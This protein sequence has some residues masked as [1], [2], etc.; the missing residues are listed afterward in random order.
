MINDLQIF[1]NEQFGE[2]KVIKRENGE[3]LFELYSV[4]FALGY[5]RKVNSKGKDYIQVRKDRVDNVMKNAD[6]TGLYLDGQTFLTEDMLY[7]FIFEAK[8]ERSKPF[9]KWVTSEVLPTLRKT[10]HY[11]L[12]NR[13]IEHATNLLNQ[14]T[15]IITNFEDNL[16]NKLVELDD[17]YRPTHKNKLGYNGFIKSCLGDNA[18]KENCEKAKTQLLFLLGDYTTY[19]DVPKDILQDS[20]TKV[21]L[22]DICKNINNSIVEVC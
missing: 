10:G 4:G 5:S 19:Q 17:Y 22:Y 2:V 8:T 20:N 7:D 21:L 14:V 11:S 3:P 18:S 12:E 6:I 9:R 13:N 16:N 1:N 15:N